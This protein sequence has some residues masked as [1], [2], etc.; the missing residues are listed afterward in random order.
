MNRSVVSVAVFL[1]ILLAACASA[2][3]IPT[4]SPAP[5]PSATPPPTATK[6]PP[7][8]TLIPTATPTE[9]PVFWEDFDKEFQSGWSWIR[10]N[11]ALWSLDSE[12]GFLRIVLTGDRPPRNI[13]IRDVTS[14]NFQIITHIKFKPT[15][16]YQFAGLTIRQ[17]DD[18]TVSLGR[19]Y[20]NTQNVCVGNGI[21]FDAVQNGQ[22]TGNN[23]GTDTQMK[24][25]AY[26]R[27]DKNKSTF[28]AYYSE[29][30]TDW[31]MIGQHEMTMLD[32]KVGIFAG[33][34][35]IVGQVALFD[36]F[37]VMEIP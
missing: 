6:I 16:N 1:S 4:S 30:G 31:M 26:L 11:D 9:I 20:C 25:E 8:E 37:S 24:D 36:Y 35:F 33:Q 7:T 17:D 21:Y 29:N 23:F 32:P 27:I 22:W 15:S 13:L 2:A 14:E 3:P 19:A 10:E 18:T 28:T 34:S 12:P 5:I